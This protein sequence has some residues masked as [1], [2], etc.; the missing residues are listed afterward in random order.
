[1]NISDEIL[2]EIKTAMDL[3]ADKHFIS[4]YMVSVAIRTDYA[5][6]TASTYSGSFAEALGLCEIAKIDL[7]KK[8]D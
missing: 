4:T 6:H 8:T 2:D 5:S 1:M 7:L 3:I